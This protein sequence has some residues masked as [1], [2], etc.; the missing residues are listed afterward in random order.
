MKVR[1]T[2][3]DREELFPGGWKPVY[4]ALSVYVAL[5]PVAY[6]VASI[7]PGRK[8]WSLCSYTAVTH[9]LICALVA[10]VCK[11]VITIVEQWIP[12]SRLGPYTGHIKNFAAVLA[13]WPL[14]AFVVMLFWKLRHG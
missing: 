10:A 2:E 8:D 14:C 9:A 6:L 4:W 3:K 1:L 7:A 5:V 13:I 11:L 12:N